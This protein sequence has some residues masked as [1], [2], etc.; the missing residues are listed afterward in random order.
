MSEAIDA[1]DRLALHELAALYGD[2][3]DAKDWPG[4]AEVFTEDAVFDMSDIGLGKFRG[5]TA[6]QAHMA[7]TDR[8]PSAHLIVN[9][10]VVDGAPIEL[11][12]RVI[13]VLADRRVGVGNYRDH[14]ERT[15]AGWRIRHR[16]FTGLRAAKA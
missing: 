1:A 11:H 7:A 6:I 3:I 8:H 15:P 10:R 4:L 9:V 16:I 14:V 13:G 2:L 5:L 12:S